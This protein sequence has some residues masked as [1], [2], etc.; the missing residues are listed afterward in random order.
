MEKR[1]CGARTEKLQHSA[2]NRTLGACASSCILVSQ[3][4]DGNTE[5]ESIMQCTAHGTRSGCHVTSLGHDNKMKLTDKSPHKLVTV[6]AAK[7]GLRA[8][9]TC[10]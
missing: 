7:A 4:S 6:S 9:P 2:L 3:D 8:A 5:C 1:H 10:A